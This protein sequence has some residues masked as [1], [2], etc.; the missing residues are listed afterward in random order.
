MYIRRV[1]NGEP[2]RH[3]I[4]GDELRLL[5]KLQREQEPKSSHVFTTERGT[6]FTP[7]A[8]NRLI[9]M[10]GQKAGLPFP[11]HFHMLRHSCGYELA[12]KGTD[13]LVIQNYL[14]HKN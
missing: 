5:R 3:P 1:K 7:N 4:R 12:N 14:G 8:I 11:V 13:L 6:P 10:L 9:K 2:C